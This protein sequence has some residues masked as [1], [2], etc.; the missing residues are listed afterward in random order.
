MGK[1]KSTNSAWKKSSASNTSNCVEVRRSGSSMLLRHSKSRPEIVLRFSADEWR[2][3]LV[4][5]R[6]GEF[7][8]EQEE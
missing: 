5:A 8:W 1:A 2:A 3:F 4:G 6:A 7:E